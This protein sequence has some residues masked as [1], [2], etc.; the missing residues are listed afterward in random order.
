[1][2]ENKFD[3]L[4]SIKE[5]KDGPVEKTNQ[6][7]Q[8]ERFIEMHTHKVGSLKE[9]AGRLPGN[10]EIFFIWTMK[11]FNAF[12]FIPYVIKS[13]GVIDNLVISTYS[14]NTR[15]VNSLTRYLDKEQIKNIHIFISDS[16]KYR[17]PKVV[18]LLECLNTVR[19]NMSIKYSWNHSKVTLIEAANNSFVIE[20]SSNFSENAQIEQYVFLNNKNVY[21]FR[22]NWIKQ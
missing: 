4:K 2:S 20:G 7:I 22:F 17:M 21:D 1:M 18:D 8:V 11:S 13:C 16:I 19:K 14:I 12:T 6:D 15:I 5:K 9:L 3:F 10:D